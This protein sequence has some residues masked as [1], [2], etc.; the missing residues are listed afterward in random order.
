MLKSCNEFF[1]PKM[2]DPKHI[3]LVFDLDDTLY[4]E[5]DYLRSGVASVWDALQS[6]GFGSRN[7]HGLTDEELR[8]GR[9]IDVLMAR[10]KIPAS[11]QEALLW[12]YRL[13]RPLIEL[14]DDAKAVINWAAENCGNVAIITDG[15]SFSQRQKLSALG[16]NHFACFISDEVGAAKPDTRAFLAVQHQMAQQTYVYVADNPAKDFGAPAVL[17]WTSFGLLDDGRNLHAQNIGSAKTK[18]T[19]WIKSLAELPHLLTQL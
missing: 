5:I 14:G 9:A 7:L 12:I 13:H 6:L 11:M 17:G 3:C 16:L 8:S 15:R 2:P 1:A 18:P 10:E 4:K 19:A